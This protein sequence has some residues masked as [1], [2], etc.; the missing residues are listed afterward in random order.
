MDEIQESGIKILKWIP[1]IIG[2][3]LFLGLLTQAVLI[4]LSSYFSTGS[5]SFTGEEMSGLLSP[6]TL[7]FGAAEMAVILLLVLVNSNGSVLKASKNMLGGKA[8]RVEG[9]L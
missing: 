3:V 6:T 2:G 4:G 7:M 5:L 8:E 1:I 9:S